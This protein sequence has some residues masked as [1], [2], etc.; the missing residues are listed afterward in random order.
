MA[1]SFIGQAG[2]PIGLR[3]NNPGDLRPGDDWQ[4]MI[5][6]NGGFIVFSD[7]T[8]G[9]RAMARDLTS[10]INEGN[11]TIATLI[12]HY[13]PPSENDTAG[14]ITAV[15]S[16]TGL[17]P[18]LQLGTDEDTLSGLIRAIMNHELGNSYSAM[19]SDADIAQGVSM[20]D[21]TVT[22]L[23]QAIPVSIQAAVDTV[24]GGSPAG[25]SGSGVA[26]AVGIAAGGLALLL[27]FGR[28]KLA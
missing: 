12:A 23:V 26:L 21:N 6:S 15:S 28:K 3:N 9:V 25:V 10:A 24:T 22:S 19:V 27:I 17:D 18:N 7:I 20:A 5:G 14:Y 16:D 13:A 11:D 8:W 4:G 2:L 1:D